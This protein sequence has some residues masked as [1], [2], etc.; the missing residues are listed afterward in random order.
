MSRRTR[1]RRIWVVAFIAFSPWLATCQ[2]AQRA[3]TTASHA[4]VQ[5]WHGKLDTPEATLRIRFELTPSGDD[6][7]G[8][9]VS[10]DQGNVRLPISPF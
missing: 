10:P 5:V 2:A 7:T 6:F 9:L 4:E 1:F 8:T 3:D